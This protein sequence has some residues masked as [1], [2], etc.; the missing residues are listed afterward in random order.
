MINIF[1][2]I[3]K[4]CKHCLKFSYK[5]IMEPGLQNDS[6]FLF[7]SPASF[8]PPITLTPS[9]SISVTYIHV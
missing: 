7:T 1:N 3:G 9:V 4:H 8:F 5:H 6:V 2:H